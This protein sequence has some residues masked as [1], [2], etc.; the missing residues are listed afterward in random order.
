MPAT[1]EDALKSMES[2]ARG[3]DQEARDL[4][5]LAAGLSGHRLHGCDGPVAIHS[6]ATHTDAVGPGALFFCLPGTS[7]DGHEW[8]AVA[9]RRGAAALLVERPLP[10]LPGVPQLEVPDARAALAR[11]ARAF[12]GFPDRR[13]LV[14]AVTGTNGKTTTAYMLHALF[15]AA[16]RPLGLLGT[17]SY[18]LGRREVPA[19]LTTPEPA[20]L[21]AMLAEMAAAGLQGVALEASSHALAQR[22]LEGVEVDTAVFTNLS[23]DHLDYHGSIMSYFAAKRRLFRARGGRK[24]FPALA[25]V[26]VDGA[27][28]RLI[29]KEAAAHRQVVTYGLDRPADVSGRYHPGGSGGGVLTVRGDWGRGE[30]ALPLP[31]RHNAQNALAA[32]AAGFG[33]G[34][35]FDTIAH[36]IATM[37]P[38]PGRFEPVGAN[39]EFT[40]VVDFAHNPDGLRW[41][42]LA[43]RRRCGGRVRLVFGCKGGDG[44]DDKRRRMGALAGRLADVVYLTTDDPYQEDPGRIVARVEPGLSSGRAAYRIVLDRAGAIRCAILDAEP[45]DLVLVAGRGHETHQPVAG[46]RVAL[47][48]RHLCRMALAERE[49]GVAPHARAAGSPGR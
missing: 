41:A 46:G 3:R 13:L 42:L 8:A 30:I 16:R 49:Q 12:H 19:P 39:P 17:V 4:R 44:D 29:A 5:G 48:D 18:R 24:P 28:G 37:E 27:A 11:I 9:V 23:R 47:D 35:P 7:H 21:H 45:G 32:A 25:V 22:R 1:T 26:C 38:V 14:L 15:R 33:N 34:V 2:S 36:A 20:L 31:G 6:L 43:A 10:Y 40:V